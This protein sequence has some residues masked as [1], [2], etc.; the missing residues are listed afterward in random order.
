MS[1]NDRHLPK[2]IKAL[3]LKKTT[4]PATRSPAPKRD[5]GTSLTQSAH[6][7]RQVLTAYTFKSVR[8]F[9]S[10]SPTAFKIPVIHC[11]QLA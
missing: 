11:P 5:L 10:N 2:D 4:T 6:S 1:K 8:G 3:V 9:Q 7:V